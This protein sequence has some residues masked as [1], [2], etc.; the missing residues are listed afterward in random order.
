MHLLNTLKNEAADAGVLHALTKLC[1]SK[2]QPI[3]AYVAGSYA[4]GYAVPTSDVDLYVIFER[5]LT[6]SEWEAL[7]DI[8]KILEEQEPQIDLIVYELERLK[9]LGVVEMSRYFLHVWGRAIHQQIPN[10]P[11]NDY[12]YRSMHRA[13]VRMSETR[14]EKPFLWPLSYPNENEEYKGYAWRKIVVDGKE[15]PSLKEI[16][17]LT[18]WMATGLCA[19][20]GKKYVPTKNHCCEIFSEVVGGEEARILREVTDFCRDQLHYQVPTTEVDRERLLGL[21]PGVLKIENLFL[22]AYRD[23]LI[24]H[25]KDPDPVRVETSKVRL[26]EI[27]LSDR[28]G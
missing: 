12:L 18:G 7:N 17:V 23:F 6:E 8:A 15:Q 27:I 20:L 3:S 16:V 1:D 19:W 28:R 14:K 13:Y 10:P 25:L 5:S 4:N 24:A 26:G 9:D 22:A 11:F 21:L 2:L